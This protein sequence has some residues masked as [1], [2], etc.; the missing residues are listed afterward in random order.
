MNPLK[1]FV[2][3]AVLLLAGTQSVAAKPTF[4]G[5]LG[6]INTLLDFRVEVDAANA[7]DAAAH[8]N[9]DPINT[10][11]GL[12]LVYPSL[13]KK[14]EKEMGHGTIH[15]T[16]LEEAVHEVQTKRF[17]ETSR[18]HRDFYFNEQGVRQ[19]VRENGNGIV[20]F[21]F[22]NTNEDAHFETDDGG[23]CVP[24]VKGTLMSF[25]GSIPHQTIVK[26]GHV[27]LIGPFLLSSKALPR[28]LSVNPTYEPSSSP[29]FAPSTTTKA[30]KSPKSSKAANISQITSKQLASIQQE[31]KSILSFLIAGTVIVAA[32]ALLNIALKWAQKSRQAR[33]INDLEDEEAGADGFEDEFEDESNEQL[34]DVIVGE[35][36]EI[37]ETH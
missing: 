20:G 32:A 11:R 3:A 18:L 13:L 7:C 26:S 17:I 31:N 4:V 16:V 23:L 34:R 5:S 29:S 14:I 36:V 28:V 10:A 19:S 21:I 12:A 24:V 25:D 1:K 35:G 22:G 8:S 27:E 33:S 9:H 2:V 30:S 6:G 37:I 15:P